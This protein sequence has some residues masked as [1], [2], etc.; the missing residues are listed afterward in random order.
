MR[1][2]LVHDYDKIDL[3]RVWHVVTIDLP[4]LIAYVEPLVPPWTEEDE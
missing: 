1:N 4:A 3:D 2:K